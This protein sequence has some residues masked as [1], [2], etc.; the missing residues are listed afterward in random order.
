M[1]V[2]YV[3]REIRTLTEEDRNKFFNALRL[4][5]SYN[6]VDGQAIYGSK[7]HSAEYF[8][9]LHL[10]GAGTSDCDHW[11]DGAGILPNH[12]AITLQFEQSLQSIDPSISVPYWE[13][14]QDR[15]LYDHWYNSIVFD[16]TWFGENSPSN[17]DHKISDGSIWQDISTP[18]G[19][20]YIDWDI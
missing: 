6:D 20:D 2:K 10:Q 16:K 7:F 9:Y 18:D 17:S 1:A 14:G 12:V 13:Y 11:H 3:R 4:I 5:F 19:A 15:Y 8:L